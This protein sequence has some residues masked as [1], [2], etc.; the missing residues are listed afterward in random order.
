M[1]FHFNSFRHESPRLFKN[2]R[3]VVKAQDTAAEIT[4]ASK[5]NLALAFFTLSR[6]RRRDMEMFYAFC[7]IV[8]DIA[9]ASDIPVEEKR[10]RLGLWREALADEFAGEPPLAR[11]LR[12]IMLRYLIPRSSFE[13]IIAGVEMDLTPRG[14]QNF[15]ELRAYCYRVASAV[16]LVSIEI[17]G[18][19]NL[20]CKDYAIDLGLALQ[21]TN[22]LRDVGEDF[23]NGGRIYLPLDDLAQFGYTALDIADHAHDDRFLRLMNFEADRAVSFYEKAIA[24]LPAEDRKSIVAAE[25]M[26][27]VYWRILEK[28]RADNFHVYK[29]RYRLNTG[30][31]LAA[32][33]RVLA[34]TTFRLPIAGVR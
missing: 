26:R 14:Y 16:G 29:K 4:R 2:V 19:R 28:M 9:D 23:A 25:I 10:R 8:D 13:E 33:A 17:F 27:V 20:A 12:A 6:Q 32:I 11:P 24:E 31:K 34:G 1:R 3:P 15:E 30:G 18:Y 22:I 21:L 7:R 5:S